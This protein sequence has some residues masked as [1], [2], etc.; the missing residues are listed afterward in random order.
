M[1]F[2]TATKTSF[3]AEFLIKWGNIDKNEPPCKSNLTKSWIL[4]VLESVSAEASP[5]VY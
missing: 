5:P 2:K 1:R 3:R 4:K